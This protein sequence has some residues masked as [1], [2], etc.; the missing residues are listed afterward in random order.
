MSICGTDPS[1]GSRSRRANESR[2]LRAQALRERYAENPALCV[3]CALPLS[4]DQNAI[5]TVCCSRRCGFALARRGRRA[6]AQHE[7]AFPTR[8]IICDCLIPEAGR[9][10]RRHH[11]GAPR[12]A[13]KYEQFKR[14]LVGTADGR[15]QEPEVRSQES[16]AG[17]QE[18]EFQTL[19]EWQGANLAR[20]AAETEALRRELDRLRRELRAARFMSSY[21][22]VC[23]DFHEGL[24][25]ERSAERGAHRDE[26]GLET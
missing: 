24:L 2:V 17:S 6:A 25:C 22:G 5:G 20:R 21:C 13:T 16:E 9:A 1:E 10:A 11:C 4:Y 7:N 26:T 23:N 15:S 14:K 18:E 12:C 8:C 19:E 3:I